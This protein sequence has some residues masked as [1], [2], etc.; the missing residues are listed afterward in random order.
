MNFKSAVIFF[1]KVENYLFLY[2]I[3]IADFSWVMNNKRIIEF[4]FRRISELL[5]PRFRQTS[6]A[7][8]LGLNNSEYLAPPATLLKS[9]MEQSTRGPLL[10]GCLG[11]QISQAACHINTT[12]TIGG[13]I[14]VQFH[15]EISAHVNTLRCL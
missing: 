1:K 11:R 8:D 3:R 9:F 10:Q 2:C 14:Q 6:E 7:S 15:I 13:P 4:G 12:K 5:R